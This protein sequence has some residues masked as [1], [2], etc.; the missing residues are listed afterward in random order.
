MVWYERTH[1]C[2]AELPKTLMCGDNNEVWTCSKAWF[3]SRSY[4]YWNKSY[5]MHLQC[6]E[7][8]SVWLKPTR[9]LRWLWLILVWWTR[10]ANI[11]FLACAVNNRELFGKSKNGLDIFKEAQRELTMHNQA[12]LH[13][14]GAACQSCSIMQRDIMH[15]VTS[16]LLLTALFE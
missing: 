5:L 2:A 9:V 8:S 4:K 12:L 16:V 11:I 10:Q 14:G 15:K 6:Q 1:Y 3:H 7:T 13:E